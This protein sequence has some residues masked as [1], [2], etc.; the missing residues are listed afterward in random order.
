MK[1][2]FILLLIL[3][4]IP[5][6]LAININVEQKSSD[7]VM[8]I[9]LE[10]PT[11]F[12]LEVT[13]QGSSDSFTFY[14]FFG[15]GSYPQETVLIEQSQTKTVEFGVYPRSDF[16][17]RGLVTFNLFIQG[18]N[19]SEETVLLDLRVVD[20]DDSIVIGSESFDSDSNSLQIYIE[21]KVNFDFGE[22]KSTFQSPF[23]DFEKEFSL[24]KYEK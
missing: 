8:I 19:K 17:Q 3:L 15:A 4:I 2:G 14:T 1:K 11:I 7:E 24:G 6:I 13:N 5:S 23:F 12:D 18:Q 20:L 21:N 9:G 10:N 22:V 16:E